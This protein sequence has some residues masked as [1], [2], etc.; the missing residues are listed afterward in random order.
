[1]A[2]KEEVFRFKK[3]EILSLDKIYIIQ[4]LGGGDWW[5]KVDGENDYATDVG[6]EVIITRDIEIKIIVKQTK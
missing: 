3:G 4:G 5:E 1:M 2:K 6:E